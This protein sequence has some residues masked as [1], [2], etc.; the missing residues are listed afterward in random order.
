MLIKSFCLCQVLVCFGTSIAL[1][2][3]A[4]N[5]LP[6]LGKSP[7]AE[8]VQAM[9]LEEKAALV[10]GT[11]LRLNSGAMDLHLP[12]FD[13]F[14]SNRKLNCFRRC[15]IAHMLVVLPVSF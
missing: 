6:Q 14:A 3:A 12:L 11:G 9:T 5:N 13:L 4:Q 1:G 7:T 15:G 10:V 8:V 2:T